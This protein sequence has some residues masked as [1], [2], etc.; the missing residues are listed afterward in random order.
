MSNDPISS[1]EQS[2]LAAVGDNDQVKQAFDIWRTAH[3]GKTIKVQRPITR[4][5]A[6]RL[7]R[8]IESGM[9]PTYAI[10][11]LGLPGQGVQRKRSNFLG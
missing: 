2:V 9:S 5:E 4:E 6:D 7:A 3:A 1:L 10:R 8:L 11:A